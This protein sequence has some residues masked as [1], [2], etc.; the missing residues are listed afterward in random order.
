MLRHKI[1]MGA[2]AVVL[3]TSAS[4]ALGPSALADPSGHLTATPNPVTPKDGVIHFKLVGHH[5][6]LPGTYTLYSAQLMARCQSQNVNGTSVTTN[7]AGHFS[8]KAVG[9]NCVAGSS[10]VQAEETV[11]PYWTYDMTLTE[12]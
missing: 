7:D 4:M 12:T 1:L 10:I 9:S 11:A 8:Y 3:A 2:A 5:L 6:A